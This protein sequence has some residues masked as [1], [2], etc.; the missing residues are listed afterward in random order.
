[1]IRG[2]LVAA[3][4]L[5]LLFFFGALAFK[6]LGLILMLLVKYWYVVLAL[7]G[8]WLLVRASRKRPEKKGIYRD[9]R[10]TYIETEYRVEED[11]AAKRK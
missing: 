2:W 10:G 8:I 5:L 3:L 9:N 7:A 6:F 4:I 11:D 1:M